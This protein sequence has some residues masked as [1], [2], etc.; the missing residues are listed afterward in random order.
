MGDSTGEIPALF[1]CQGFSAPEDGSGGISIGFI[2]NRTAIEEYTKASGKTIKYGV[3]AASQI[4]LGNNDLFTEN[5]VDNGIIAFDLS[6]S[7]LSAFDL[8]IVGFETEE[9]KNAMIAMGA[10][11]ETID[12]ETSE[13][14]Y[15]QSSA[16]NADEKYYYASFYD[17]L[18]SLKS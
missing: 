8:R 18:E 4:K 1:T 16:P 12:G 3:F 17:V 7:P 11:V 15:L 13:Y 10:Y 6:Y 9:Q 2:V 5:G 14:S